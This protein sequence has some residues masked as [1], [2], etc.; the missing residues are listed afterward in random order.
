MQKV[1]ASGQINRLSE[2]KSPKKKIKIGNCIQ[3][4]LSADLSTLTVV[5]ALTFSTDAILLVV[6]IFSVKKE[7]A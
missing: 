4:L 5:H 2:R 6:L 3:K 1:Q 7:L